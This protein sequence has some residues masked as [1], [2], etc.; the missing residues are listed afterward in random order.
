MTSGFDLL[1]PLASKAGLE[2]NVAN[3]HFFLKKIKLN[4]I[5]SL[6]LQTKKNFF[7]HLHESNH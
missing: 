5:S 2:I 6:I 7:S 3:M 4:Q 1:I